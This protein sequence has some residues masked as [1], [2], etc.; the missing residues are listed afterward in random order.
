MKIEKD[1]EGG[2]VI[3]VSRF[4]QWTLIVLVGGLAG[5]GIWKLVLMRKETPP[6]RAYVPPAPLVEPTPD[7]EPPSDLLA[8]EQAAGVKDEGI[9]IEKLST[10]DQAAMESNFQ[11]WLSSGVFEPES[12]SIPLFRSLIEQS[13]KVAPNRSLRFYDHL[14]NQQQRLFALEELYQLWFRKDFAA[15]AASLSTVENTNLQRNYFRAA[16]EELAQTDPKAA[17][18]HAK[19]A[20][21]EWFENTRPGIYRALFRVWGKKN[22]S[23]ATGNLA[24]LPADAR[25]ESVQGIALGRIDLGWPEAFSWAQGLSGADRETGL[26]TVVDL[27]I[28]LA[29]SK[30]ASALGSMPEG[31]FKHHLQRALQVKQIA[32]SLPSGERDRVVLR[33]YR[34]HEPYNDFHGLAAI[35]NALENEDLRD[36]YTR[37]LRFRQ[38]SFADTTLREQSYCLMISVPNFKPEP[39]ENLLDKSRKALAA[40]HA[41]DAYEF[42]KLYLIRNPEDLEAKEAMIEVAKAKKDW[43]G[44]KA[45]ILDKVKFKPTKQEKISLKSFLEDIANHVASSQNVRPDVLIFWGISGLPLDTTITIDQSEEIT[46]REALESVNEIVGLTVSA[47]E[48]GILAYGYDDAETSYLFAN[49]AEVD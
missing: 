5:V 32:L 12:E 20:K 26:G 43:L 22:A 31:N 11:E 33:L 23:E 29:T 21:P 6:P 34:S 15:A 38:P 44:P 36:R 9:N 7:P 2:I 24:G 1:E 37:L 45:E 25:R 41:K 3:E 49:P 47:E 18:G 4:M 40:G 39:F 19:A 35:S 13:V 17:L 46:A 8:S 48:F 14:D 42:A 30:A 16:I 27:G 10:A 28:H